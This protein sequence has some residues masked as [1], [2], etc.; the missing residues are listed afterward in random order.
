M[1]A[2]LRLPLAQP[3]TDAPSTSDPSSTRPSRPRAAALGKLTAAASAGI[4]IL[5]LY[6]MGAIFREF[7]P[8]IAIVAV[9]GLAIAAAILRGWRWAP[10]LGSLLS[11][12]IAGLLI[13]PAAGEI[14][15]TFTH[16]G[17]PMFALLVILFP[18]LAIGLVAG[19]AATV[20]NYRHSADRSA[21]RW[22]GASLIGLAGACAGAIAIGPI[23]QTGA[24]GS[25]SPQVLASLPA[26]SAKIFQFEQTELRVKAG[27]TVAFRLDNADAA[28]HVFDLDELNVHAPMPV[29]QSGLALFKPATPGTYTFYCSLHYDKASGQG[30]K[31]TLVVEA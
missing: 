3:S 5:L 15:Y 25:V 12:L 13:A 29:G 16:P 21:P 17:D 14:A 31:G 10:A 19:I 18:A 6:M 9:L 24:A 1:Q 26:V 22:L 30:M 11:L 8:P 7:A 20:Q 27:Q 23:P 4:A 2:A 28:A